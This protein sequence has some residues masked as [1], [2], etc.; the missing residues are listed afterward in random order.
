MLK[1]T[2]LLD[3]PALSKNNGSKPA[4][5]KNNTSKLDF[6][7]INGNNKID[8]F[9]DDSTKYAKKSEKLKN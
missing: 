8:R 1:T 5:S 4:F 9:G 6:G 3:G 7:R 2:G